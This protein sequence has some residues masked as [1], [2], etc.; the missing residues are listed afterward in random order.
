MLFGTLTL[1][2][3]VNNGFMM[4]DRDQ[5]T[6]KTTAHLADS[7]DY[8]G[9]LHKNV[10][11]PFEAL[12][13][14]ASD[15]GFDLQIVSGYRSYSR[16][17]AIWNA[18][19]W[20]ERPLLDDACNELELSRLSATETMH[21]ILRWSA[22]PGASRHHW[23]T[24]FDVY[25]A[26]AVDEGYKVQLVPEETIGGGPFT[27]MHKWLDKILPKTDFY[28]PYDEDCGGTCP[29]RWHLSYR[30][31]ADLYAQKLSPTAILSTLD[32]VEIALRDNIT[33]Q[34]EIIFQR[35]ISLPS[36]TKSEKA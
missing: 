32:G 18:K 27:P 21:A 12:R 33:E 30:P 23:G 8:A 31:V 3:A 25:D 5:A 24:D 36:N 15:A 17:L 6:G 19:A 13:A 29:E 2:V 22:L 26:A 1:I 11:Q 28:R 14:M 34:I 9:V 16:Q 35:Y 20:G 7:G 10:V 4:V